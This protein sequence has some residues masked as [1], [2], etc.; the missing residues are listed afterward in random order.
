MRLKQGRVFVLFLPPTVEDEKLDAFYKRLD[1]PL[2]PPI[3]QEWRFV[4]VRG[5]EI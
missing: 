5:R 4:I 3:L 2:L 1:S